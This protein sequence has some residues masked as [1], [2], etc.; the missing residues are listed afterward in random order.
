MIVVGI[1]LLVVALGL[2]GF[3]WTAYHTMHFNLPSMF[4]GAVVVVASLGILAI[5]GDIFGVVDWI[6]NLF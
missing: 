1:T 6:M 4:I 2:A 5:L 3:L